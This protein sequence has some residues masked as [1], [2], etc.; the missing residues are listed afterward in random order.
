MLRP[1]K[2]SYKEFHKEKN[3]CGT[4]FPNPPITFLMVHPLVSPAEKNRK[5]RPEIRRLAM[6][7]LSSGREHRKKKEKKK[8][9]KLTD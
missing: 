5:R 9:N 4:K 3:S 7:Q 8:R 1:K 6:A 2:K